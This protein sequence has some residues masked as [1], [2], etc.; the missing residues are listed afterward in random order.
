ME[1]AVPDCWCPT[2]PS[3]LFGLALVIAGCGVSQ[4]K[5]PNP[6]AAGTSS[7]LRYPSI[8]AQVGEHLYRDEK[9]IA[10]KLSVVIEESV[11][12]QYSAGSARRDAHPKAHGCVKAEFHIVDKLPETLSKGMFVPGKTYQAWIRFSNGSGDPTHADIKRDARGMAIKVLGVPGKK[13]LEDEAEA[14]TQDFIMINHPVFFATDPARYL[15]FMDDA[16]SDH[17]Y[18]KLFIPFDLGAKGTLIA[19]KTRSSRISNPLQTRYWSMVPYQLGTGEGRQ[20]VKYSARGCSATAD[21]LPKKPG[22]DF[23]RDALQS[24][25]QSGD[26]CMEFLV[27][28]RTSD[29]MDVEDSRI[30]WMEAKAPFYKL[31]TIR[32]LPQT[33]D[34]PEQNTFCENLSFTP[35]HALSEHKPL[36]VTNRLR[37]VIYDHISRVRH[38]MNG[39]TRLEP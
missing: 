38:E 18:R 28:P 37:K 35:W 15:S 16:N 10:E 25:L 12:K 13:L 9:P 24:T 36:G 39:A 31:A 29:R 3:C 23:L 4:V 17:F 1:K 34:T 22:H 21:P 2:R 6:A 8:D 33:F 32:V 14:T 27:Q 30:E 19:L 7:V 11:R 20:A 26:A 5:D